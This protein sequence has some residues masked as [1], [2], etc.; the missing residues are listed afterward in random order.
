MYW[1]ERIAA[2]Q[3]IRAEKAEK[4]IAKQL[5]RYYRRSMKKIIEDYEHTYNHLLHTIEKGKEP[6]PADLYKL[7]TYWQLQSQ[8]KTELQKL[9]D[10]SAAT[11]SRSFMK[12]YIDT[13]NSLALPAGRAFSTLSTEAAKQAINSIWCVD[14]KSWSQR[15]WNNTSMLMEALNDSL[16]DCVVAGRK[17]TEL[18]QLLQDEFNVSYNRADTLVRTEIAH[19]QTQAA[20]QRYKDY[21]IEEVEVLVGKDERTCRICAKHTGER[22]PI[23]STMPVPFHPRCR[24][25]MVPVLSFR[26]ADNKELTE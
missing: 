8:L 14:G 4:E 24:C 1:E 7:D 26:G 3:D 20:Q 13:Y 23:N 25:C 2:S 16:I 6:T 5:R 19:I 17:T 9:G 21:G 12:H 11:L 15:V 22:Y 10:K 18:K